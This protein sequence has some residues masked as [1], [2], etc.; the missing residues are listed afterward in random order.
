MKLN[1]GRISILFSDEGLKIELEDSDAV[2]RFAEI[3]LNPEQTCQALS[4]LSGTHCNIEVVGLDKVGKKR[5][6]KD[7]V[8]P[9]P[10]DAG[11]GDQRRTIAS[12]LA[13]KACPE[14]WT[15]SLYFGSQNSFFQDE[16]GNY[17]ARCTIM[18]WV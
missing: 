11:Y 8:F 7:L 12:D 1:E 16:D 10:K 3:K 17:M 18:R 13:L 15:P 2:I 4:R 14:G 6:H 9:I 5:E